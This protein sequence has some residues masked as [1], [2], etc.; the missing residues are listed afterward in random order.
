MNFI[1]KIQFTER[2]ENSCKQSL[3]FTTATLSI[4]SRNNE[5]NTYA[6]KKDRCLSQGLSPYEL[7]SK[8]LRELNASV[9]ELPYGMNCNLRLHYGII[10]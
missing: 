1:L 9:R 4:H 5:C 3:Q 8:A 7:Q 6:P 2:S 10:L